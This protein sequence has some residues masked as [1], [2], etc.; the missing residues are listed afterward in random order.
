MYQGRWDEVVRVAEEGL[1]V[2]WEI[3]EWSSILWASAW[4]GV[5]Y[6]KLGRIE[7]AS[8]VLVGR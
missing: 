5:A 4:L 1:P 6:L 2:A 3:L 8:R 7:D